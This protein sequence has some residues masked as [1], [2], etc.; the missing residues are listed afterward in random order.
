MC[1]GKITVCV[2]MWVCVTG[3]EGHLTVWIEDIT[4]CRNVSNDVVVVI[5]LLC[6]CLS[7]SLSIFHIGF[8][9]LAEK[10]EKKYSFF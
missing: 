10:S 8:D 7:P 5:Y 2:P 3:V 1:L 6:L 4:N 9:V